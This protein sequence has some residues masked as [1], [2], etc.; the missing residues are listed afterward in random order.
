MTAIT[1]IRESAAE[2]DRRQDR[3]GRSP[4]TDSLYRAT[5]HMFSGILGSLLCKSRNSSSDV[6]SKLESPF[7]TRDSCKKRSRLHENLSKFSMSSLFRQSKESH[8]AQP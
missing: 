3:V 1:R 6:D 8:L 5:S 4:I 7:N 2:N